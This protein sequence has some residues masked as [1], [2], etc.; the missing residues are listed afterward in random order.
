M[1]ISKSIY[2]ISVLLLTALVV[3]CGAQK[4][5]TANKEPMINSTESYIEKAA[6]TDLQG[7]SV[8]IANYK[9]KVV[10]IDFWETWCKPCIAS[11][12]TLEKLQEEYPDDFVVLAV[13]PGFTD[14]KK[15]AEAFADEHDYSFKYLMDSDNLS[16]KLEVQSIPFKVFVDSEGNF[17]K[18]SMGSYGPDDDYKQAKKI[19]EE[20]KSS[21]GSGQGA[22]GSKRQADNS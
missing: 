13:T 12:P 20:H 5:D 3:A 11:F 18:T 17:I 9:G 6:F 1:W 2:T 16:E 22:D 14:S 4:S 21:M 8:N 19:I 10:M 15:D 7:D